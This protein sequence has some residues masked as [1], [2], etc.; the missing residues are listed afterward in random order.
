[1]TTYLPRPSA[2]FIVCAP[3][4]S[5]TAAYI[6]SSLAAPAS[7]PSDLEDHDDHSVILTGDG[8]DLNRWRH[9]ATSRGRHACVISL[10]GHHRAH[11]DVLAWAKLADKAIADAREHVRSR[12]SA[13]ERPSAPEQPGL[14]DAP[15]AEPEALTPDHALTACPRAV[16]ADPASPVIRRPAR[17]DD[18]DALR[19]WTALPDGS[20]CAHCPLCGADVRGRVGWHLSS[21]TGHDLLNAPALAAHARAH[22]VAHLDN[23]HATPALEAARRIAEENQRKT[24]VG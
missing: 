4:P 19:A 3:E 14:F 7:T 12:R 11:A 10:Q 15:G 20:C 2:L 17:G 9:A 16:V 24:P 5:R 21:A 8:L 23:G 13:P 22:Y 18:L 6:A 1:M